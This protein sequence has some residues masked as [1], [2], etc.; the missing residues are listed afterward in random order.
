MAARNVETLIEHPD[1]L[2]KSW[3]EICN[4]TAVKNKVMVAT[5]FV[6]KSTDEVNKKIFLYM[7]T[8]QRRLS[9]YFI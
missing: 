4:V 5:F 6:V 3:A 8:M 1:V 9:S 7:Q 2:N